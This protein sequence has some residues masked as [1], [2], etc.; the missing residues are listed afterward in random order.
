MAKLAAAWRAGDSM[1]SGVA[2]AIRRAE[3]RKGGRASRRKIWK[4]NVENQ[5]RRRIWWRIRMKK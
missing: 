5:W 1:K 2:K 4:I 3:N